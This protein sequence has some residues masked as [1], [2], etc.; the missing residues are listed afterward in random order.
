MPGNALGL[1]L[2]GASPAK[3]RD[4]TASFSTEENAAV[5]QFVT[6]AKGTY[7]E[8]QGQ[9]KQESPANSSSGQNSSMADF[10]M[11]ADGTQQAGSGLQEASELD[12][13][14]DELLQLSYELWGALPPMPTV[15]EM[16]DEWKTLCWERP[17]IF[18][19]GDDLCMN[20][21][22]LCVAP[23]DIF[24]IPASTQSTLTS[25]P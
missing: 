23:K 13:T 20:Q 17:Q 11:T 12:R 1:Y 2:E 22:E 7:L 8:G 18:N 6:T 14:I 15:E 24:P 3:Q 9:A 16:I 5:A 21:N 25:W 4:S 10:S 19:T